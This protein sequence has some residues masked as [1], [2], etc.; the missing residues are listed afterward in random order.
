MN[1]RCIKDLSVPT[2]DDDGFTIENERF[3][4]DKGTVWEQDESNFRMVG[5]LDSI[6]LINIEDGSW[7]EVY[8]DTLDECFELIAEK[9]V[10]E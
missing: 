3:Y 2:C 6:R 4:I 5:A 8:Q 7:L 1:Y 9:E 10:E